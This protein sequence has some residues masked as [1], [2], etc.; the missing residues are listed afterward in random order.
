MEYYLNRKRDRKSE[1]VQT[2]INY[3]ILVLVALVLA[4]CFVYFLFQT[5]KVVGDSM[6]PA[7]KDGEHVVL[8]R[9]A[10]L[11]HKPKRY[12]VIKFTVK[13]SSAEHQ[14]IKRVIGLP[15]ETV[16]ITDGAVYINDKKLADTVFTE[17]I[18][19]AGIAEDGITLGENEYFVIGDNCNNSEDSRFTNIG[20]VTKEAIEGKVIARISGLKLKKVQ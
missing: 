10:Y 18:V 19:T 4:F 11:L 7:L 16:R 6:S 12:D 5:T 15:K 20:A 13:K 1:I 2:I 14:Y 8:A 9:S 17:D 3:V